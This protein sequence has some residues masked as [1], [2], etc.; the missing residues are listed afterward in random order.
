MSTFEI[1]HRNFRLFVEVCV[2]KTIFVPICVPRYVTL[3]LI[4]HFFIIYV[5]YMFT[6]SVV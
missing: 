1:E 4:T 2:F 5:S 3:D 6:H